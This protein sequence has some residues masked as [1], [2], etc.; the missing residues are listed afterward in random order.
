VNAREA[1]IRTQ[2]MDLRQIMYFMCV[3][4]EASFTKAAQKVGVVQPAL[5]IQIRRLE[6]EF[7]AELFRRTPKGLTPT[8]LGTSFYELCGPIRQGVGVARQKMTELAQPDQVFGP[9]RCGF[10]PTF[11][12]D[13]LGPMIADFAERYPR[14]AL[15]IRDA[16]SGSL[17]EWVSRGELDF[18][19]GAWFEDTGLNH[20][21]IYEEDIALVS[22][23]PIG[24]ETL[25]PCDMSQLQNLKLI[26]PSANQVL[27]PILRQY[28]SNGLL[29]PTRTMVVDSYLGV[30]EIARVSDWAALIPIAGILHEVANSNIYIYPI[31]Y[32]QL[33]FRWHL[34]HQHGRPL[35]SAAQ[36]LVDT[37][38]NE[39]AAKRQM[40]TELCKKRQPRLSSRKKRRASPIRT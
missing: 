17:K 18:A 36:L 16:Y 20:S 23:A 27:G 19:L 35:S 6:D 8:A 38:V 15:T 3:Y 34:I 24:G 2:R 22:G 9:V 13:L 5:S 32:P 14:V 11:F 4:E 1:A 37:V 30:L 25:R 39:L 7:G 21:V 10:P 12:K 33:S 40:W 28:I 31:V 29:H 26:L